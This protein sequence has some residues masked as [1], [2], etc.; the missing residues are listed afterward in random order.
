MTTH[1]SIHVCKFLNVCIWNSK[2]NI[3]QSRANMGSIEAFWTFALCKII[4]SKCAVGLG[5]QALTDRRANRQV[6]C[7]FCNTHLRWARVVMFS[8]GAIYPNK[9]HQYAVAWWQNW[10]QLWQHS[11][12][13]LD[14]ITINRFQLRSSLNCIKM[15]GQQ[16]EMRNEY[17]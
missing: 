5:L 4:S 10:G 9:R 11:S 7:H 14:T 2:S 12:L 17:I 3:L 1:I 8:F 6:D 15:S 16:R 13:L